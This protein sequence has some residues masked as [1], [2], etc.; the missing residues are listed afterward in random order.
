MATNGKDQP[1]FDK[2]EA[3]LMDML[4]ETYGS[5][6][7]AFDFLSKVFSDES[8]VTAINWLLNIKTKDGKT[9]LFEIEEC[10]DTQCKGVTYNNLIDT[11]N[12]LLER[13]DLPNDQ[14]PRL[15]LKTSEE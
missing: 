6:Q 4:I 11:L 14:K 13:I 9:V 3:E 8:S 12:Y 7:E 1:D 2:I 10:N 15:I 5:I